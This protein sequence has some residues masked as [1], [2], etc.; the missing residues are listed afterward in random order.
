MYYPNRNS[1]TQRILELLSHKD[2]KTSMIH[3]H[4]LNR[5]PAGVRNLVDAL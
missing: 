1:V 4:V 2:L 5:G 3:T